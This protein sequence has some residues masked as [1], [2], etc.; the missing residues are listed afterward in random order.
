MTPSWPSR[1][2]W[3][4]GQPGHGCPRLAADVQAHIAFEDGLQKGK[5]ANVLGHSQGLVDCGNGC[6]FARLQGFGIGVEGAVWQVQADEKIAQ[7]VEGF[8]MKGFFVFVVDNG[9]QSV[10]CLCGVAS[11]HRDV[12]FLEGFRPLGITWILGCSDGTPERVL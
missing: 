9:H 8:W 1:K 5:V 11:R 3:A 10:G 6:F 2:F 7:V 12:R 4:C